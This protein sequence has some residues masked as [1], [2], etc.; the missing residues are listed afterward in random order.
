MFTSAR[1]VRRL[2]MELQEI[3]RMQLSG[4]SRSGLA[5]RGSYSRKSLVESVAAR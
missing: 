2:R 3:E 1:L 5:M 4:R